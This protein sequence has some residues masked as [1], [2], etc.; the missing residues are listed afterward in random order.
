MST[1]IRLDQIVQRQ[2]KSRIRERIF[3]AAV[4]LVTSVTAGSIAFAST[5][6]LGKQAEAATLK[7]D[8]PSPQLATPAPCCANNC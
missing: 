8:E 3:I 5:G 6:E 4:A 7:A 2:R 1:T